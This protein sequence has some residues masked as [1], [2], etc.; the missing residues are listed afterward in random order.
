MITKQ[1]SYNYIGC[2]LTKITRYSVFG[3]LIYKVL[4]E[5]Y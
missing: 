3:V 2:D 1:V 4:E 5:L